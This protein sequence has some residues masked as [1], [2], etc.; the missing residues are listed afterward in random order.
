MCPVCTVTVVAGLGISRI[1]GIDDAVTSIWIG[2]L[3]LSLSFITVNW[4][5][6]RWPKVKINTWRFLFIIFMYLL[7]LLPLK[8]NG[9]IG[10]ERNTF[11]GID[12]ILLG[13][14]IGSVSFLTGIWVDKKVRKLRG[15]QLI[16][17]QKVV[18]PVLALI[19]SSLIFYIV[20]K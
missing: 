4:I 11:W 18:L 5:D 19:I 9:A 12:K 8:L 3:I 16:S 17:F 13:T 20:T 14:S 2:G 10:I 15:K 7:V 6:K 1:L